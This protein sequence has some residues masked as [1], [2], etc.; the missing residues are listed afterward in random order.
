M[1]VQGGSHGGFI[2]AHLTARWPDYF[3]AAVLRNPVT[4]LCFMAAGGS[5][6]P[7]WHVSQISWQRLS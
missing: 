7:D 4:D 3:A 1:F 5:D 6:I 2:T